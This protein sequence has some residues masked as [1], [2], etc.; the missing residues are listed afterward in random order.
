[1]FVPVSVSAFVSVFVFLPVFLL[2]PASA[3]KTAHKIPLFVPRPE[4]H[5]LLRYHTAFS[6]LRNTFRDFRSAIP[7]RHCLL[8]KASVPLPYRLRHCFRYRRPQGFSSH[9][10]L[11]FLS[12]PQH[13]VPPVPSE[14]GMALQRLL[15]YSYQFASSLL[16][17]ANTAFYHFSL[18]VG[19]LMQKQRSTEPV[20]RPLF[21]SSSFFCSCSSSSFRSKTSMISAPKISCI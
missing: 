13:A 4:C 6:S 12:F 9:L 16:H 18:F 8:N 19:F 7:L 10:L 17:S 3:H 2:H 1:M 20:K 21:Y 11:P 14:Q 5:M 15:S